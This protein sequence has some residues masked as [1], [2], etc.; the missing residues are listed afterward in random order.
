MAPRSQSSAQ[1]TKNPAVDPPK[2]L[3]RRF[4]SA[5]AREKMAKM[6]LEGFA[7]RDIAKVLG[8]DFATIMRH[9]QV[10]RREGT[11]PEAPK[12]RNKI[13]I[14]ERQLNKPA[15]KLP[16]DVETLRETVKLLER[17]IAS[18]KTPPQPCPAKWQDRADEWDAIEVRRQQLG[19]DLPAHGEPGFT[20]RTLT[21]KYRD[22]NA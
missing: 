7:I 18:L 20:D 13:H 1:E 5:S 10:M 19:A 11:L 4:V 8:F 2:A 22:K 21:A 12:L 17:Q 14:S 6:H 15:R 16:E 9:M 3:K